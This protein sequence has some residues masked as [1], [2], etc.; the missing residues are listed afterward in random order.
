VRAAIVVLLNGGRAEHRCDVAGKENAIRLSARN[1][2]AGTVREVKEGVVTA[3]VAV[4]L[5]G[6]GEI[7]SVITLDSVRALGIKLGARVKA[8][9][10]STDVMLATET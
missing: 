9:I 5:D 10:K 3:Q 6:G 4:Q 1:Q 8:V 7:V 2:L